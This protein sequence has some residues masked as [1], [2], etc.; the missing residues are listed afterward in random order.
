MPW[1]ETLDRGEQSVQ[2]SFAK[3]PT[4]KA[5]VVLRDFLQRKFSQAKQPYAMPAQAVILCL[6][7]RVFI[8]MKEASIVFDCNINLFNKDIYF[9]CVNRCSTDSVRK[10]RKYLS[11]YPQLVPACCKAALWATA[12]C[13]AAA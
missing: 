3:M 10:Y 8:A 7:S 13:R 2:M 4:V 9:M 11:E 12:T 6:I 5:Y 1:H